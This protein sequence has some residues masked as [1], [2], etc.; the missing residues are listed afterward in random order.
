MVGG[1]SCGAMIQPKG[2]TGYCRCTHSNT[3]DAL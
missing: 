1:Y 2:M 3:R